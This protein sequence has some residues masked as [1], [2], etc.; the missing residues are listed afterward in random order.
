MGWVGTSPQNLDGPIGVLVTYRSIATAY[1]F[2]SWLLSPSYAAALKGRITDEHTAMLLPARVKLWR[3]DTPVIPPGFTSYD[4]GGEKHFYVPAEFE[5]PLDAGNYRIRIERG[6]EYLPWSGSLIL[7]KGATLKREFKLKRWIDMRSR[8]WYSADLHVHRP[9]QVMAETLLAEDLH[10]APVITTHYWTQWGK[11]QDSSPVP[12]KVVQVDSDHV[13]SVGGFE[14]ERIIHGPGAVILFGTELA[15]RPEG[16][17]FYPPSSEFTRLTHRHGGYVDGDKLFWLDVPVNVALGEIDFIQIACNHF[18]PIGIDANLSP[19]ASWKPEN[20]FLGSDKGFALWIMDLYYK[21]LNCGFQLPS[22]GGS[23]CGVKPL[24]VGYSRVYVKPELPFS[25][26]GFFKALKQGRSFSTNGP[27][28][29]LT[30][31]GRGIGSRIDFDQRTKL[32]ITAIAEG[33]APLDSLEVIVNGKR[34]AVAQGGGERTLKVKLD[35]E[36]AESA[37]VA[38]RAFQSS[39]ETVVFGHTSPIYATKEGKPVRVVEDVRYWLQRVEKL[40]Q[41]TRAETGFKTEADRL[42]VLNTYEQARSVYLKLLGPETK[43]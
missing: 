31:N 3:G 20:Q 10:V 5:I 13:F 40:L 16:Y 1:L 26:E 38:A 11:A 36:V 24:P 9:P 22:S 21:F 15:V 6:K 28:L 4:K 33:A 37:W 27:M 2:L 12:F 7:P 42:E 29:D 8:G 35:R 25:Y 34:A 18:Y 30:V 17:E 43:P 32:Q 23:A 41:S 39:G 14:I 19:W